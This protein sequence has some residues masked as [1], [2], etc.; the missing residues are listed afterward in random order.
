MQ[1]SHPNSSREYFQRLTSIFGGLATVVLLT[2]VGCNDTEPVKGNAG[3]NDNVVVSKNAESSDNNTAKETAAENLKSNEVAKL[4]SSKKLPD[5][6]ALVENAN[7]EPTGELAIPKNQAVAAHTISFLPLRFLSWNVESDGADPIVVCRQLAKLNEN[8]RYDVIG[9]TEVMP[10]DLSKFRNA[11]GKYYKY[12][13]SKT[14]YNDR[15]QILYNEDVFKK[16]R[17]FEIKEINPTSRYRSPLVV[18]LQHRKEGH[19]LLVMLNHL[20][21]GKA[22]IRQQQA[23]KLVEWARNETLPIVAIGDYNFD[24]VFETQ[25]GNPAFLNMLRDNIWKWVKPEKMIDTNW[26]DQITPDGKD[27]YPGSMLDFAFVANAAKK[28]K[29]AC[30]IIVREGD[31]PDDETTSDHRPFELILE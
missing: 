11:L 12:A 13:Y 15:L 10:A 8:D 14:G 26:Y 25:R 6:K 24:Y 3:E 29:M 2:L 23:T 9:L 30:R 7:T 27:D 31:F 16:L 21:R 4:E 22:E 19:E 5:T 20:A 18:H 17:H 1:I 28:W